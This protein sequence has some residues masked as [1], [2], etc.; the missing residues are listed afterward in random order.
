MSSGHLVIVAGP[1][2]SGKSTLI[3]RFLKNHPG[4]TFPT[5][6]TTREPRSGEVDGHHYYFVDRDHFREKIEAGAFLE[7]AAVYGLYYGTLKSTVK[8]G[9]DQGQRFLKDIDI[10]GANSLMDLLPPDQLTSIFIAPPSL[11]LLKQRLMS[12]DTES[13]ETLNNRLAEAEVEMK[14]T[15]NF[16][17]V[18]VNDDLEQAYQAFEEAILIHAKP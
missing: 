2:G 5:S 16:E 18:I 13:E 6:M 8:D 4:W 17:H 11:E 15:E 7:W 12:R 14:G 10:Q 1:S 3:K 9:L